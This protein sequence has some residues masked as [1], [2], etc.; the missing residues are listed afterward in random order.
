MPALVLHLHRGDD[1]EFLRRGGAGDQ[2]AEGRGRWRVRI[3]GLRRSNP[4]RKD[5]T[6]APRSIAVPEAGADVAGRTGRGPAR[7]APTLRRPARPAAPRRQGSAARQEQ[8]ARL[9]DQV[10]RAGHHHRRRPGRPRRGRRRSPPPARR[11]RRPP[12]PSA[13]RLPGHLDRRPGPGAWRAPP[14]GAGA[15]AGASAASMPRWS[16]SAST[17][18]TISSRPPRVERRQRGRQRRGAVRV[19]GAVE[20]HPAQPLQPPRP[21]RRWPAR[22]RWPPRP[23]ARRRAAGPAARPPPARRSPLVRPEER[24]RTVPAGRRHLEAA[25][26][27]AAASA[28]STSQRARAAA[29]PWTTAGTPGLKMPA[30]SRATASTVSPRSWVWSRPMRA[31]AVTAGAHRVGGVEPAA[32]PHLHHRH[33]DARPGQVEQRRQRGELE[34]GEPL[35]RLAAVVPG[36]GAPHR[37]DHARP[38]P[39]RRWARRPPA[40]RS[41]KADEVRRGVEPGAGGRPARSAAAAMAQVEPLPLVPATWRM[42]QARS[43]WPSASSARSIRWSPKR[44]ARGASAVEVG[45][46]GRS[47]ASR[48]RARARQPRAATG[49]ARAARAAPGAARWRR[50][51][52]ARAGT[53]SAGSRAAASRGWSAR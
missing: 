18:K 2:A 12:A 47:S 39:R 6:Q 43:G 48:A 25:R 9:A 4:A 52:R 26:R 53:R 49:S 50:S 7:P 15:A 1:V 20:Q 3:E 33:L 34:V 36:A 41:L 32:Q 46:E 24:Q 35:V 28:R 27:A 40:I 21:A 45:G 37:L 10:E 11:G 29:P 14:G 30:F 23:P 17:P 19:V 38:A 42:G 5:N 13:G 8:A 22:G 31:T 44:I 16:L 51:C